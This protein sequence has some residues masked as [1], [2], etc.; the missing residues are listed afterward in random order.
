[1]LHYCISCTVAFRKAVLWSCSMGRNGAPL[2]LRLFNT[3]LVSSQRWCKLDW[4]DFPNYFP[5]YAMKIKILDAKIKY[6]LCS[7]VNASLYSCIRWQVRC[8]LQLW[9]LWFESFNGIITWW[10]KLNQNWIMKS[11][12]KHLFGHPCACVKQNQK[13]TKKV[14]SSDCSFLERY[15]WEWRFLKISYTVSIYRFVVRSQNK[16]SARKAGKKNEQPAHW[17][18]L[19]IT[20][21][22]L[23]CVCPQ[24]ILLVFLWACIFE[25][26]TITYLSIK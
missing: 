17:I 24:H 4:V 23:W 1:M 20:T 16:V 7:C 14:I 18:H 13:E 22:R 5:F 15:F 3:C 10:W 9:V 11:V 6:K 2:G 21:L 25:H 19:V 12:Y 8:L 26:W